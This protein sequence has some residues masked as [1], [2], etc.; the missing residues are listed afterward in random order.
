MLQYSQ[1]ICNLLNY[2]PDLIF[3]VWGSTVQWKRTSM[4]SILQMWKPE[5]TK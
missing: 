3:E 4:T 5:M 1:G 2:H